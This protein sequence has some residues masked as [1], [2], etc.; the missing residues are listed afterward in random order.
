M[1]QKKTSQDMPRVA[2]SSPDMRAEEVARLRSIFPQCVKDGAIDFDA[3]KAFFGDAHA[4]VGTE[5]YGLSW[6]GKTSAF[7]AIRIPATGT[8]TP[9]KSESVGWDD[10][11][12]LFF[13]GDNLEVLKLLQKRY[14]GA[15]KMIYIDPPYNTGK[16]FVYTDNFTESVAE[17]YERTGQSENGITLTANTDKNGRYHSDWLSMMYPRLFLA[18]NLLRDDGVIFVSID[19]NEVANLRLIMDEI[20]GEENF[21]AQLIW[22]TKLA[23]KGVPPI[24]MVTDI[25]EYILVYDRGGDFRFEGEKRTTDDFSNPDND[26]RGL[27][28]K[29]ALVSTIS[30]KEFEIIDP[31]TGNRFNRAWAFSP[32]TLM[33]MIEEGRVIF[34]SSPGGTPLQK[35][36]FDDYTNDNVPINTQIGTFQSRKATSDL[37]NIFSSNK[38]FDFPKPVEL[39]KFIVNQTTKDNDIILDF[40]A[41]SGTTAHAVMAQNAEDGGNRKWICVQLP[42]TT[43]EKSE[44]HKAGYAT[45]SAIARERIRRAGE[46]IK[47]GDIGFKA[48]ALA[49]S[50][51]RKWREITADDDAETLKAQLRLF[52]EKPLADGYDEESVV[53]EIMVKEGIDLNAPV[54]KKK[55]MLSPWIVAYGAREKSAGETKETKVS[56]KKGK[57]NDDEKETDKGEDK[58]LVVSFASRVSMEEVAALALAPEGTFVCLDTALD[59]NTKINISRKL[60]LKVI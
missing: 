49:P 19:D 58:K 60:N 47:T 16:D 32:S 11:D 28:R 7:E 18:K 36:F 53:Y 1:A 2:Q 34:P 26:S 4:V 6:A 42:E 14:F 39:I 29:E 57:K 40:F 9:Q 17:Y 54:E 33:K 50:N 37:M 55:G 12:N 8:L 3:L 56:E 24:K 59:D 27:W 46:K 41:G 25:H 45:I 23:S 51:Y 35:K 38:V 43:D 20:F 44:A 21:V 48:F 31:K 5:K 15:V 10:T 30:Q 13:E 22:N 52:A